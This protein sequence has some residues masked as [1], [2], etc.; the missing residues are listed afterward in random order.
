MTFQPSSPEVIRR[1]RAT[2]R[3]DAG[4]MRVFYGKAKDPH[5]VWAKEMNHGI[6]TQ[7]SFFAHE[8]VNPRPKSLFQQRM[9]DK[10]ESHY[11]SHVRAPLGCSH[12]QERGLPSGLNKYEFTFGIPTEL[13]ESL[14]RPFVTAFTFYKDFCVVWLNKCV[15]S[16]GGTALFAVLN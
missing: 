2:V 14:Y 7:P 10:K 4:E 13:G 9:V 3:P 16:F 15:L 8:L 5:L 1:F 6:N 11:A 12:N